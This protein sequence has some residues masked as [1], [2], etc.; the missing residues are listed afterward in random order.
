MSKNIPRRSLAER[1]SFMV[2]LFV[3]SAL[4]TLICYAWISG[5]NNPPILSV[6][7]SEVRVADQQY[8]VPF[9]ISNTGGKTANSVEVVAKL[10]IAS[11]TVETGR[12]LV[13][14]LSRQ[15]KRSGE[16]VFTQDPQLGKL[17]VRIS[18][19]KEP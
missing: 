19:Y 6:T 12:Q 18:S 4:V 7:T 10:T 9:T 1:V 8:Y 14:F 15:E 5:D 17:M 2:S 13:D 3:V 11:N 16:F